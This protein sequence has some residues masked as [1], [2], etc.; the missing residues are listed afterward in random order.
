MISSSKDLEEYSIEYCDAIELPH[1]REFRE[2][3]FK[4][5]LYLM[6]K[7]T[8]PPLESLKTPGK[9]GKRNYGIELFGTR[10]DWFK[11][12]D[13]FLKSLTKII[14]TPMRRYSFFSIYFEEIVEF[15]ILISDA[16]MFT[17]CGYST[18]SYDL[19]IKAVETVYENAFTIIHTDEVSK[20]KIKDIIYK[21]L[22]SLAFSCE[23]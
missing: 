16:D 3:A 7:P 6:I 2:V 10:Q 9:R 23:M 11:F 5:G 1:L 19:F 22:E 15:L 4:S 17:D 8:L 13:L 14:E 18:D 21:G 20:S 12:I